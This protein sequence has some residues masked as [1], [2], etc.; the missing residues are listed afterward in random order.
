MSHLK[1]ELQNTKG[2]M[3]VICLRTGNEECHILE[4][5]RYELLLMVETDD[6]RRDG[7]EDANVGK[8]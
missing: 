5:H 6:A 3:L 4:C 8:K 1:V 2:E 7:L